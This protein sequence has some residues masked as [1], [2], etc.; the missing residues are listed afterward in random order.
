VST[1]VVQLKSCF[2]VGSA[3]LWICMIE[4]VST[5]DRVS[6]WECS[7]IYSTHQCNSLAIS[8]ACGGVHCTVAT[9]VHITTQLEVREAAQ[10]WLW[11]RLDEGSH[12]VLSEGWWVCVCVCV[13][14][15]LNEGAS[16]RPGERVVVHTMVEWG[17]Y[18]CQRRE[19]NRQLSVRHQQRN[20]AA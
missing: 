12:D 7:R 8:F 20:K 15:G 11:Y 5:I 14:N 13:C 19:I 9:C 18:E 1:V 4:W 16:D 6:E 10:G 2:T 3:E 17:V